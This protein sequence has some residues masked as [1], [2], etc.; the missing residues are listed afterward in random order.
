MVHADRTGKDVFDALGI[1][2]AYASDMDLPI[3]ERSVSLLKEEIAIGIRGMAIRQGTTPDAAALGADDIVQLALRGKRYIDRTGLLLLEGPVGDR[4]R[5]E[6]GA[7]V[8]AIAALGANGASA[9]E[10]EVA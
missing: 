8:T 4:I 1:H 9:G 3:V 2:A 7:V 5:H 10:L 6:T